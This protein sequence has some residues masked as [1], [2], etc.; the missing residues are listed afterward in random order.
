MKHNLARF[1]WPVLLALGTAACGAPS[2][3]D[4]YTEHWT[5][6]DRRPNATPLLFWAV[7]RNHDGTP[8]GALEGYPVTPGTTQ[9]LT[10]IIGPGGVEL[11]DVTVTGWL[12]VDGSTALGCTVDCTP[13]PEDPVVVARRA[14][15]PW[16]F[17][18]IFE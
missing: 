1:C 18:F 15:P 11:R 6:L 7:A 16:D 4:G 3:K 9:H 13:A 5:I 14:G 10:F 8:Y 12:D 17:E 2:T